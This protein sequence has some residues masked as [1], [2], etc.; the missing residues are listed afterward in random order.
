MP[1]CHPDI[2]HTSLL[3]EANSPSTTLRHSSDHKSN[4]HTGI[5]ITMRVFITLLLLAVATAFVVTTPPS[6]K[7]ATKLD[8]TRRDILVTGILASIPTVAHAS[9]STFF[10]DEKIEQVRE[11]SQMLTGDK[12]D[13]NSAFVVSSASSA[14]TTGPA[15][16]DHT[17]SGSIVTNCL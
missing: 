7:T 5:P 1:T 10:Y 17:S 11:P 15:D 3:S 14:T 9:G 12:L 8:V 13:L 16:G 2:N 4:E 6:K